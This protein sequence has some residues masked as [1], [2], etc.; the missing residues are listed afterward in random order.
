MKKIT[1]ILFTMISF[2][3]FS[4]SWNFTNDA[5]GWSSTASDLT[6]NATSITITTKGIKNP[7]LQQVAA[8]VDA[9]TK[10][11]IAVTLRTSANSPTFMRASFPKAASGRVYKPVVISKGLSDFKT[12]YI[13]L[14]N[15]EWS[16]TKNDIKLHFKDDDGSNGGTDHTSTGETIEVDKIE[17]FTE[18]PKE[19]I[20]S[21]TFDSDTQGWSGN[22]ATTSINNGAIVIAPTVG[23]AA[24]IINNANTI[25]ATKYK[26]IEIKFKNNSA[27]N[28]QLRFQFRHAGDNFTAYKGR[29]VN[30]NTSSTDFETL[31]FDLSNTAE[32]TGNTQD[33][34]IIIR[35][36]DNDNKASAGDLEIDT[37]TF[38]ETSTL[39]LND[40]NVFKNLSVYPNPTN[41]IIH[42]KTSN[43]LKNIQL[44]SILG[45][46]VFESESSIKSQI[47][48][49]QVNP[50]VYLLKLIDVNNKTKTQ[51]LIIN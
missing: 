44:F 18:I 10:K 20:V 33:F 38:K 1:F 9:D 37:I 34:Q 45:K 3:T 39:S 7:V 13:D 49:P 40:I 6:V 42:I 32:W 47:N 22:N 19:T 12:Y 26:F 17:F 23:K 48:L 11:V 43:T 14:T 51:K 36:V 24:K 41:G 31:E 15:G 50:G 5:E 2:A 30:M 25:D 21:F 29:N 27:D 28:D 16:G 46:K 4:Q 8:N 35:D